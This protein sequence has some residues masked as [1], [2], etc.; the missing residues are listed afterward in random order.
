VRRVSMW[1]PSGNRGVVEPALDAFERAV[2][3]VHGE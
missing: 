2:A 1:A 3:D